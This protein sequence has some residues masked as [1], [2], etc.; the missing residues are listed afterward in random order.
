M[1]NKTAELDAVFAALSDPTRRRMIERLAR[2]ERSVGEL[3][4]DF[5]ISQPAVSKHVK[6]LE[7]AGLLKRHVVGRVHHC[8][9]APTA[10][11][12]ASRWLETQQRFWEGTL[13]RLGAYIDS[14]TEGETP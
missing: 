12:R 10:L 4:A 7:S 2:A 5:S 3:A 1:V 9:L 13:D 11:R 8:R 6:V 14:S